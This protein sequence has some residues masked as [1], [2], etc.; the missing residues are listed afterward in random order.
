MNCHIKRE[1]D[2]DPRKHF[3]VNVDGSG[4]PRCGSSDKNNKINSTGHGGLER[5]SKAE[6]P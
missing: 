4:C 3:V 2:V 1:D 5:G 6:E